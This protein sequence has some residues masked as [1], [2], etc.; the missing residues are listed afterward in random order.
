MA[1]GD[2]V[3]V[4]VDEGKAVIRH[5]E[6]VKV[7]GG[8]VAWEGPIDGFVRVYVLTKDGSTIRSSAYASTRVVSV[9]EEPR[10]RR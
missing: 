7:N 8:R 4:L 3:V 1:L 5:E 10:G 2:K 6:E 9:T